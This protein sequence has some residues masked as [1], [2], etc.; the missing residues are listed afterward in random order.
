MP[1]Q[2]SAY[3][4]GSILPHVVSAAMTRFKNAPDQEDHVADYVADAWEVYSA[5]MCH[6]MQ[7]ELRHVMA[8]LAARSY[9]RI[10]QPKPQ[11][12]SLSDLGV[13]RMAEA[14]PA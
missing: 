7:P 13:R 3:F 1:E 14:V 12:L 2:Q 6:M 11:M 8:T 10:H 4:V 9:P 5:L